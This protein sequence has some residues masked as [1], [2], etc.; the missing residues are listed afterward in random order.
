[1]HRAD[2]KILE[3]LCFTIHIFNA[4]DPLTLIILKVTYIRLEVSN[5]RDAVYLYHLQM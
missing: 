5:L 3:S 1:M 2:S 4:C